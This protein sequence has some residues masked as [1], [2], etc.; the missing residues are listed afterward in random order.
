MQFADLCRK[1][2]AEAKPIVGWLRPPTK[3]IVGV[4]YRMQQLKNASCEYLILDLNSHPILSLYGLIIVDNDGAKASLMVYIFY[5][6]SL[7]L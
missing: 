7:Y 6:I 5:K 1:K 2:H 4:T 3:N